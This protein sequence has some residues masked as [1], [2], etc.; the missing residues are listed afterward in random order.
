MNNDLVIFTGNAVPNL[1]ARI[2]K[3]LDRPLG[4]AMAKSFSDGETRIEI[5]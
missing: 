4:K 3:Y 2:C 1:A 5:Q